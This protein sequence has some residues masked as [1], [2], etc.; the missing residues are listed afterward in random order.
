MTSQTG[1]SDN[2]LDLA[3]SIAEKVKIIII[4]L[5]EKGLP[6]PSLAE[7]APTPDFLPS[8]EVELQ[9]LRQQAVGEARLLA[10]TLTGPRK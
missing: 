6:P 1:T 8:K 9:N 5:Q 10:D 2:T 3:L 4:A 7:D